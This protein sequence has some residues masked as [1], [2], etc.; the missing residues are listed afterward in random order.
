MQK[1]LQLNIHQW[2]VFHLNEAVLKKGRDIMQI[3][4]RQSCKYLV[5]HIILWN[6]RPEGYCVLISNEYNETKDTQG[7]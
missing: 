2:A 5:D 3:V 6:Q 1:E 7:E 4:E